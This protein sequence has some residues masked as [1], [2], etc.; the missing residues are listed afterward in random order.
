MREYY[1]PLKI[2]TGATVMLLAAHPLQAA[3]IQVTSVKLQPS[4]NSIQLQLATVGNEEKTPQIFTVSRGNDVVADILNSQLN[5]EG[6][7]SF[8]QE[9]PIP[10]IASVEVSQHDDNNIRI[11]VKGEDSLPET[12]I[13]QQ[14]TQEIILS[15]APQENNKVEID[16]PVAQFPSQT[17]T[18]PNL[19]L[20]AQTSESVEVQES[21]TVKPSTTPDVLFPNPVITI[22][23]NPE[24]TANPLKPIAPAP[25]FLP[26]AVAPPVGDIAISN[27]D[28]SPEIIDLGTAARVSRLVLREAPVREVLGTLARLADLNLVFTGQGSGESANATVSLDLENEPIQDV[29]NSVLLVSGFDANRRGRTVF[30]GPEL[31][32]AARNLITRTLRLN[33]VKTTNAAAFLAGQG[34]GVQQIVTPIVEVRS[35]TTGAVVERREEPAEIRALTVNQGEQ[36]GTPLL[37][38]GLS[39]ST[40][41]RLNSITL[42]GEPRKVQLATSFLTQLDARRRQVAIN[43][44]ILDVN[45]LNTEDLNTSF[46]FGIGDTFFVNDGGTAVINYGGVNPPNQAEATVSRF[47]PPITQFPFPE[48]STAEPFFDPQDAPFSDIDQAFGVPFARPNFGTD[49]N[50]FQPGVTDINVN[51]DGTADFTFTLPGLFQFPTRF[52]ST[53]QAEIV[54]GNAKILTDPTLVVQEGQE[55]TVR[56]TQEVVGNIISET[57]TTEGFTTNTITAEIEEA[58]LILRV[59]VDSIDDNGFVSLSVSPVVT[60]IGNTQNLSVGGE[61][62]VIA[63]LNRR[64]LSSGLIRL[65]DSQTLILSGIIQE[66]DTTTVTKVPILGDL[67][68]IGTLFRATERNNSRSEVIVL[69]TPQILDDSQ[70]SGWGY[71]YIPGKEA[72]QLLQQRGFPVQGIPQQ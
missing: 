31:P 53:L 55:A 54:N 61:S 24:S 18:S 56:L 60:S 19:P 22:E 29:F 13:V 1:N 20:I 34:A 2:L 38:T 11:V 5:L 16:E 59:N 3:T 37:L 50:P 49:R 6:Q 71:N 62:N 17:S 57:E 12:K 47:S 7:D 64:E 4:G 25:V 27:I 70:Q 36:G 68:I 69:L 10:G 67:P 63:L 42:I 43:V 21:S 39:V 14:E 58:G 8:L 35:P 48:G 30:V 23:G 33:Q 72:N 28:S 9:S 51:D 41:D 46:S 40:D 44:K 65:R 26:R 32:Q 66:S 45:L 52:L 15:F